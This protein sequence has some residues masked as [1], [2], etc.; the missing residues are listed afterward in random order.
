MIGLSEKKNY[1]DYA[2]K[3]PINGELTDQN[4]KIV[5]MQKWCDTMGI[6]GTPTI[7]LNG[8]QLPD[9]YGIEDLPYFLMG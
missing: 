2:L 6:S 9:S 1:D 3:Y 4:N 8:F 5:Q 7:F